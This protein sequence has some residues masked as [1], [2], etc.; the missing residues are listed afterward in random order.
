MDMIYMKER[1]RDF[2][3]YTL[4]GVPYDFAYR[5]DEREQIIL[6]AHQAY[7][8]LSRTITYLKSSTWLDKNK[9]TEEA[10]FFIKR[11]KV[12]KNPYGT[13]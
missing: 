1:T 10:Q 7:A 2:Y 11:K 4:F 8:D 9:K 12:S 13:I 5:L 6:C 3:F